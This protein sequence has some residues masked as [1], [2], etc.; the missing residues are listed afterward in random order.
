[1]QLQKVENFRD[2]FV[3]S[4]QEAAK[5][6]KLELVTEDIAVSLRGGY[7]IA[8]ALIAPPKDVPIEQADKIFLTYL[9]FPPNSDFARKI[10]AGFYTIERV[11][12]QK[13]HGQRWSTWPARSFWRFHSTSSKR[14]WPLRHT[15]PIKENSGRLSPKSQSR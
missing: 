9:S 1:M 3:T 5:R 15:L 11:P 10:R 8:N 4:M 13:I 6:A 2:D 12:D 7:V 14:K